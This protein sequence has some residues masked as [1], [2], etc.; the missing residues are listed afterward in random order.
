MLYSFDH[1]MQLRD[2]TLLYSVVYIFE[3]ML[4]RAVRNVA[5]VWPQLNTIKQH[6]TMRNKCCMMFSEML[7]SLAGALY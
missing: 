3:E 1:P 2:A 5:F 7:C 6:A 4:Y